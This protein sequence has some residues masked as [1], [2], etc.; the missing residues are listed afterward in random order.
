MQNSKIHPTSEVSESAA[1]GVG[2]SIWQYAHIRENAEIGKSSI[3]G[4]GVYVGPKVQ[5]GENCKIQNY[6]LIYEPANLED[7]V[8][9]GPSVVLTND[10]YPR[11]I[12][13]DGSLK[14]GSDWI[15]VGVTIKKG[16]SVGAGSIC[17]A[18]VVIGEWALV[19]AGSTVTKDVPEFAMVAGTPSKRIGWVGKAGIPLKKISDYKFECPKTGQTYT[20]TATDKLV[21]N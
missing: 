7:G 2:V 12:N 10:E 13:P 19:A 16:A 5:I 8:F 14:A 21:I 17:V 4:R 11:A 15:P 18:P 20:Q 6:A 9:I 1:I 3:I